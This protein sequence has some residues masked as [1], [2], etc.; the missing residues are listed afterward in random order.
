MCTYIILH[1]FLGDLSQK[2]HSIQKGEKK[3]SL[4]SHLVIK[5]TKANNLEDIM[6]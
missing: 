6:A 2:F 3:L 1:K 5:L 4:N